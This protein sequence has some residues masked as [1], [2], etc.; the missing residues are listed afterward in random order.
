MPCWLWYNV[1]QFYRQPRY[2]DFLDFSFCDWLVKL[3]GNELSLSSFSEKLAFAWHYHC[4]RRA[5]LMNCRCSIPGEKVILSCVKSWST[6]L[7]CISARWPHGWTRPPLQL[8]CSALGWQV[9]DST[10]TGRCDHT[11][12]YN[13][14]EVHLG[15]TMP[16]SGGS[17][18]RDSSGYIHM[19]GLRRIISTSL[20]WDIFWEIRVSYSPTRSNTFCADARAQAMRSCSPER[21]PLIQN[22]TKGDDR[23]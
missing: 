17:S 23:C 13:C 5:R 6:S 15:A 12:H 1:L 2:E 22:W 14:L 20:A 18:H 3:W 4:L 21:H 11:M 19:E 10:R 8:N 16:S 9:C 7:S